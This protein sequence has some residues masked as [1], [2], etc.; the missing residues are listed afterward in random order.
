MPTVHPHRPECWN[1]SLRPAAVA[2]AIADETAAE[3]VTAL[4]EPFAHRPDRRGS[5]NK[6]TWYKWL[7]SG[8]ELAAHRIARMILEGARH[9][10]AAWTVRVLSPLAA[11][12][13]CDVIPR[14]AA[15][16]IGCVKDEVAESAVASGEL[17]TAAT[18]GAPRH[19]L[20]PLA[21]NAIA[22]ISDV[23]EACR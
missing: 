4:R 19:E 3:F 21:E 14:R 20:A 18:K 5:E 6:W 11:L 13:D 22:E 8:L 23:L 15:D 10:G 2:C 9:A 1:A 16:V 12:G 7:E 17:Y